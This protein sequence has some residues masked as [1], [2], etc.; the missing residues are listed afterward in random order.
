MINP[1]VVGVDGSSG[2][3]WA[4]EWA[5]DEAKLRN[6]PL[7][8]VHATPMLIRA[9]MLSAAGYERL[10][11]DRQAM[12][13]RARA[14]ALRRV[15]G[16]AV[17]VRAVAA[18][19]GAALVAAGEHAQMLVVGARGVGGF[20]GLLLGSVSLFAASHATCPIVTM[21]ASSL[22][23]R[24]EH[25][26]VVLGVDERHSSSHAI[27]WAFEEADRRSA[28]LVAMHGVNG[29]GAPWQ[30]IGEQLELA[31]A[32][33]GWEPKYPGLD[34]T[35]R[36]VPV[37]PAR[38]LVEM[39]ERAALIVLGARRPSTGFGMALGRVNHTV[40]NHAHCPT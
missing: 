20:E 34:V 17:E 2:S 23:R 37:S 31:E 12:L 18:D 29:F 16:L 3:L 27:G 25:G 1:I 26:N 33:A 22:A 32:L 40:L 36:V 14:D 24:L 21:P 19:P 4:V 11:A 15:P 8:L 6:V 28:E 39:S 7:L 38:A 5:A 13:D 9:G 10:E 30:E 35:R